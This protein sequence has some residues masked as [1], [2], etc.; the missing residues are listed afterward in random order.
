[1]ET[2][3]VTLTLP[4]VLLQRVKVV[5][6]KRETSIS[7]LMVAAVEDIV[8]DDDSEVARR[9]I[10]ERLRSGSDLGTNGAVATPRAAL[11]ER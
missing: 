2:R 11:H 8:R 1:M 9:R 7:A 6:A 3:N 10:V 5:A 4:R